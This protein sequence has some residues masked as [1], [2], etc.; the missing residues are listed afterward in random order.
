MGTT[1]WLDDEEQ[2]TWRAFLAATQRVREELDRQLQRD[3]GMPLAYY[4]ILAMLSEA[5]ERTLTMSRLAR[6]TR[7]SASRL[8]HAVARL[9]AKGWV[10]RCQHPADHRT[11]LATL[12]DEGLAE[13]E[14]I[15]PGHV[16]QVRLSL[17]DNL[18][19]EQTRQLHEI[20]R[21]VLEGAGEGP[22]PG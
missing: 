15:A 3:A 1:R 12:T 7:S 2:R 20:C 16:E 19:S 4:Q 6:T 17:F 5:P 8:S 11:T 14:G 22:A 21:A 9:E 13:L 10:S 18:T